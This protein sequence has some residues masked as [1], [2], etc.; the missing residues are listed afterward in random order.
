[1]VEQDLR[2]RDYEEQELRR[3]AASDEELNI[4]LTNNYAFQK[5]FK[6]KDIVK[7]FLMALLHLKEKQ[8]KDI[9]IVDPITSGE[10][11]R[12]KEGILD[13]KLT[14][15]GNR[16]INIEMQNTYQGD[17]EERSLFYNCRMFTEGFKKGQEYE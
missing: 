14:L 17:W 6:N 2:L 3:R 8:I 5:I 4:R 1:M 11:S 13:I 15:N 9:E 10:E 7:G 12:E 16:K